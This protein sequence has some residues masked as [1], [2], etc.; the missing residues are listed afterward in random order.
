M[1]WTSEKMSNLRRQSHREVRVPFAF[2]GTLERKTPKE[3]V[4]ERFAVVADSLD[5]SQEQ[6][7]QYQL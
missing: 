3:G 4:R 5:A 1:R 6:D 2:G 7:H